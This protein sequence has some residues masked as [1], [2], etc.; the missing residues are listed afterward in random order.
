MPNKQ[1]LARTAIK[2]RRVLSLPD[3]Q[4]TALEATANAVVITD[5]TGNIIWVNSAFERL[6][7]FTNEEVLGQTTRVLKSGLNPPAIYKEMWQTILA[8][9]IWRGELINRRKD[10]TLYDEE[11]T[12]T[13]VRDLTDA[14]THFIAIKLDI[15]D[16]KRTETKLSS[17]AERLSLATSVVKMGVW[18]WN[19]VSNEF[20]WDHMMFEITG[21]RPVVPLPYQDWTAMV[22]P[23]DLP[24]VEAALRRIVDEKNQDSAEFRIVLPDG[25]IRVISIVGRSLIDEFGNVNRVI[26]TAQDIG[27]RKRADERI[28]LLSQAVEN[29]S[30]FIAMGDTNGN[31][32]FANDA[33]LRA[34]GYTEREVI[35]Q[36]FQFILS[37]NNSAKIL[38]EIDAKTLAGGWTG[39]C[40]QRCKDGSDLP[41][42]LSTG[43]LKDRDGNFTGVFGIA[44]DISDRKKMEDKLRRLAAIVE[45]SDDAIISKTLDGIIQ[46][47]NRGAERMYGYSAAEAIGKPIAM[48]CPPGQRDEI[49]TLL[50]KVKRGEGVEHY[51]SV[52][53]KKDGKQIRIALTIS[54]VRD[55]AGRIIGA[56]AIGR[57]I[58]DTK[59]MEEMFRQSQKMEAVGRL[60]GGVAHD[61]NNMLSVI[62]GYSEILLE[63][64]NTDVQMRQQ[65]EEIKRAGERAASLTRQLLAFSRQ[66]VLEPRILN[67]NTSVAEIEKM[68]RRLIGEDV[69]LR[70]SLHSALGSVK[71][72]PGQI[73]QIIMNLA[74]NARDA[75]PQGGKLVIETANELL[76]EDYAFHH[77][78]CA[79]GRY[80]SLTVTDDGAG[81]SPETKARIFEPFFTTKELGKG[82]GLGLA[83][84][85]G[86]VKQ[87]GGFVWVYSE[88]GQ[89][90]VFKIYLPR[91]DTPEQRIQPLEPAPEFIRATETVLLVEDEPSVRKLTRNLLEQGG[92]TVLEADNGEHAVD[93]ARKHSG[94]IHLLLTDV[95]MPGMTGPIL[96]EKIASVHPEAIPLYV[97]GYSGSFGTQTGLVPEGAALLQKPF[98]RA[99]LLK[100]LRSLLDADQKSET[101]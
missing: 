30:E 16:R 23:Q 5:H 100:K 31:I 87:S 20:I 27:E 74:V 42:L 59:Q 95:V 89:G 33:W 46:S 3:L 73:E 49:P 11:M 4:A 63:R 39:E 15:S 50:E 85:Y 69:E 43:A 37:P 8:G 14:A 45:S 68:L 62:I 101:N 99:A 57:N 64:T 81:M 71:A 29:S 60:A 96:V 72:D 75:M 70:T 13:P 79:P 35:G 54:P 65:C 88:L 7:G 32:S 94:P 34:L 12:I 56:S 97:S 9:N 26:G 41:V 6:T 17:L 44:R 18:Q 24:S 51:E 91:I 66:Q 36:N 53:V 47:W 92:Y 52:R 22:H 10:G 86:V 21:A 58:T 67:L 78:T 48:L 83:T 61:F 98:T 28:S 55:S 84:V 80:V 2:P 90:S 25:T 76:D 1:I 19:V 82:T 38:E 40:L 93:I 77:P